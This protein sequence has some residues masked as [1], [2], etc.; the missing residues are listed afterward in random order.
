MLG[1]RVGS[2][3]KAFDF[4]KPEDCNEADDAVLPFRLWHK[5]GDDDPLV[6]VGVEETESVGLV[7]RLVD[8]E[9]ISTTQMEVGIKS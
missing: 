4:K 9:S 1:E 5:V 2:T 6:S 3:H 8:P 7:G